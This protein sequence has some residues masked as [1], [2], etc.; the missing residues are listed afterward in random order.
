MTPTPDSGRIQPAEARRCSAQTLSPKPA[1]AR[2]PLP[3]P[4]ARTRER[5][6]AAATACDY[7]ALAAIGR[8]G[9]TELKFTLGPGT[10]AA[11]F[12]RELERNGTPV[13]ARLVKVLDHPAFLL[14]D[15]YVWPSAMREGATDRDWTALEGLYP[16]EE[17]AAMK[18]EGLGYTGIRVGIRVDGAWRLALAG[19]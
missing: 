1:E 9:G 3:A 2:P 6:V 17:L 16:P 5:I 7:E 15:E 18:R 11:V 10:D 12:W 8:E 4:V 13:L 19:D 14:G